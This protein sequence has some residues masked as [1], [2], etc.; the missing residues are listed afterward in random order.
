MRA[1]RRVTFDDVLDQ[2]REQQI[3]V[4]KLANDDPL[5]PVLCELFALHGEI[6]EK[7]RNGELDPGEVVKAMRNAIREV[8]QSPWLHR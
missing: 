3:E 5:K 2:I 1:Q 4:A 6:T 8:L 7:L